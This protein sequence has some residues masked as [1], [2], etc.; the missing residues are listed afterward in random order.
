MA[1]R[2]KR[3]NFN[4]ARRR[5]AKRQASS[6]ER[7]LHLGAGGVSTWDTLQTAWEWAALAGSVAAMMTTMTLVIQAI[8]GDQDD[9]DLSD[10]LWEAVE[11][12]TIVCTGYGGLVGSLLNMDAFLH[13][14]TPEEEAAPLTLKRRRHLRLDDLSDTEAH[15]M[16]HFFHH[17]LLRLYNL[18][19]LE[20]FLT[21]IDEDQIPLYTGFMSGDSPCR[22]FIHPEEL[23]LFT[24][25]KVATGRSNA[26]IIDQ[27]FGGAYTRW[28]YGYPWMLRY[29]TDR[30]ENIL[31]NQGLTRYVQDFPRFHNAIENYVQRDR[32]FEDLEGAW[33]F[34]PGL[35]FLPWDIFGFIDDTMYR[36]CAPFSGPRGDYAGAARKEVYD[37]AQRALYTGYKKFHG[38]KLQTVLLPN[39]LSFV[40][41]GVSCRRGDAEVLRMSGLNNFLLFVQQGLFALATGAPI[42]YAL[43]GDTAFNIGALACVVS[44]F[45]TFGAGAQ[46]T[47]EE[48]KCNNAINSVRNTIEKKLWPDEHSIWRV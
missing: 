11:A 1:P 13:D 37:D 40:F 5:K 42:I 15:K 25:T 24:L 23:F 36:S 18:L 48:K 34:I 16:T 35:Q 9:A 2:A 28:N 31:G 6:N 4:G 22:Y 38:L 41:G 47:D 21:T 27:W 30:Y 19:N 10:A 46:L 45:W 3:S 33:T 44:Y 39:G 29:I 43:F 12:L 17:Q 8:A 14:I 26:S 32:H 7:W 20:G